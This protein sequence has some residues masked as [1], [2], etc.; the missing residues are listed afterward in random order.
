[1]TGLRR[2]RTTADAGDLALAGQLEERADAARRAQQELAAAEGQSAFPEDTAPLRREVDARLAAA[3]EAAEAAY[4]VVLG[5]VEGM[6]RVKYLARLT[7]P[8]VKEAD[9]VRQQ[10]ALARSHVRMATRDDLAVVQPQAL[11]PT[12]GTH[13]TTLATHA[14]H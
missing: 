14:E 4:R 11:P 8:E 12:V 6:K 1:M 13:A 3:L 5:P 10:I 2:R 9:R 7:R